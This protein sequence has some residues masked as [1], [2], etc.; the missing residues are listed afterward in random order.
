M[1]RRRS[2]ADSPPPPPPS[3]LPHLSELSEFAR[4]FV[5]DSDTDVSVTDTAMLDPPLLSELSE[6]ARSFVE[7]D[8]ASPE[9]PVDQLQLSSQD[10]SGAFLSWPDLICLMAWPILRC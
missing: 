9:P 8:A 3:P 4:S 6:F 2:S 10:E 1:P 5:E 7:D